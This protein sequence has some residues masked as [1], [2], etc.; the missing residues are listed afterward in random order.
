MARG[1]QIIADVYLRRLSRFC[2]DLSLS[3]KHLADM[4]E[5]EVTNLLDDYIRDK[6]NMTGE[7]KPAGSY[8]ISIVKI[9]RSCLSYNG[10]D[11]KRRIKV[12]DA[13]QSPTLKGERVPTHDE[14]KQY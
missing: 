13:Q 10:K 9:V 1:S 11:I 3:S 2:D 14:L 12:T 8:L 5:G 7:G 6:E 4:E